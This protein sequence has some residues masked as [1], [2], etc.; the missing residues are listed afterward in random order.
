MVYSFAAEVFYQYKKRNKTFPVSQ[1]VGRT[2]F[3]LFPFAG[4]V[5]AGYPDT[6]AIAYFLSLY[7]FAIAHLGVN[8]MVDLTNDRERELK[9]IPVLYGLNGT[10]YWIAGFTVIHVI[11]GLIFLSFVG[12]LARY[13]IITGFLLL[14]IANNIILKNRNADTALKVLPLFNLTIVIYAGSIIL[15]SLP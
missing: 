5:C 2:D 3:A 11:T 14:G 15:G 7:P 1:L 4:Y 9:T 13:G 8:D 6:T 10:V 12:V